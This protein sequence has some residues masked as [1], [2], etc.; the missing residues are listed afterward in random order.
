MNL[1]THTL[2]YE[3]DDADLRVA[4]CRRGFD[5]GVSTLLLVLTLPVLL[6][7]ATGTAI[8]LRAWPLFSHE[9]VGLGGD[10]FRF[11]KIRTLP[12]AAPAYVDKHQLDFSRV[13][14]FC[15][16]VRRLHLD[17]LPQLWLVLRGEMSLVGPRPEMAWLHE[18]MDAEFAALR[19]SVRPGCTGLWQ[20]SDASAGLIGDAPQYDRAYLKH[21][22]L[23]LDL[24]L[25]GRTALKMVGMGRRLSIA[26]IPRW[27]GGRDQVDEIITL[28][29]V[30]PSMRRPGPDGVGDVASP[31][32]PQR[33]HGHI[34]QIVDL[35]ALAPCTA[36]LDGRHARVARQPRHLVDAIGLD[37]R[38]DSAG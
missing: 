15:R 38:H 13:P 2:R 9:R 1:V 28:P 27:A 29:G 31:S 4:W 24:W 16:L 3:G 8:S 10:R 14:A 22:S 36:D 12:P 32:S 6:V 25:L 37:A 19:T 5:I 7:V 17:E 21:R 30:E 26:D 33:L 11:L 35:E 20:V 34:D 23:R 18:Q